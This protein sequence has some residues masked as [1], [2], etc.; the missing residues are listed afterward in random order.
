MIY[1]FFEFWIFDEWISFK[2]GKVFSIWTNLQKNEPNYCPSTFQSK[3]KSS[4]QWF[5]SFLWGWDQLEN[6]FWEYSTFNQSNN[7][8]WNYK[9]WIRENSDPMN[10][11]SNTRLQL[12][13]WSEFCSDSIVSW[14]IWCSSGFLSRKIR[15]TISTFIPDEQRIIQEC[16]QNSASNKSRILISNS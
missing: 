7:G 8:F 4:G 15:N 6:T 9:Y 2:L 3:V 13:F 5:G 14:R 16:E 10:K 1:A 12:L 11:T